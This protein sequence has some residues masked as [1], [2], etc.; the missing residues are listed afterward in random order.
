MQTIQID[1]EVF[2][3]LTSRRDSEEVTFND[4][5]R[6]LLKLT[7]GENEKMIA[8]GKPWVTKEVRFPHGTEFYSSFKGGNHQARVENGALVLNG[9]KFFSPSS[10]AMNI[11]KCPVNG[12][13]FWKC[14]FPGESTWVPINVVRNKANAA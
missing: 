1:F 13:I 12:W 5:L 7:K 3:E 11:T 6:K 14:K 10:A 2:K 8:E 4:V 9:Q